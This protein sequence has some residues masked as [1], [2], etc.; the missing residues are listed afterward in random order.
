[1]SLPG[2]DAWLERP[3]VEGAGAWAAYEEWC[4]KHGFDPNEVRSE[5][6]YEAYLERDQ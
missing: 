6:A 2:Y 5:V 3:Y 1:M 4:D